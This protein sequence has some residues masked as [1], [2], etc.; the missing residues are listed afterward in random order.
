[1]GAQPV[2]K[3]L[4]IG[5]TGGIGS[6]KTTVSGLFAKLGVPVSDAD[7]IAHE[8]VKRGRPAYDAILNVFGPGVTGAEGELRRD[9][10][11]ELIFNDDNLRKQLESIIHP[12]VR[13]EIEKF[14]AAIDYP[15]CIISIPLLFESGAQDTVDRV[16]V[17]DIPQHLQIARAS[18]RDNVGEE[19]I[20]SII[21]SQI[22]R[23]RR[24]RWADDVICNNQ[25][26]EFLEDQVNALHGKYLKIAKTIV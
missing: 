8:L 3:L 19:D 20:N 7:T 11:R 15:Y 24:L 13:V 16:L 5:L 10:L 26:M 1:M 17:I 25:G 14:I 4:R 22:S 6:G 2:G 9:Y 12:L 23:E 18:G 21:K